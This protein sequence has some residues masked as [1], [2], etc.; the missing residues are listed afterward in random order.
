ME[1][2][3][4]VTVKYNPDD[5]IAEITVIQDGRSID[6]L[7][8]GGSKREL[9]VAHAFLESLR[10]GQ[11]PVLLGSGAGYALKAIAD[12]CEQQ[13]VP[14]LVIDGEKHILEAAKT[15]ENCGKSFITWATD[16]DIGS[17]TKILTAWQHKHG[18]RA[19]KGCTLPFYQ[20]SNKDF[21]A[22]LRK[23]CE[24]S[25]QF[26][27]WEKMRYTR[28]SNNTPKILILTS[29]YFLTGEITSACQRLGIPFET[30]TISDGEVHRAGFVETLLEAIT[31]FQPDFVFT[32]NHLGVD[33]EGVLIDLLEKIELPLASWFVDNPMLILAMYDKLISP[34]TSIFTWDH[35]NIP[36]LKEMGFTHVEY[37]SLGTDT[38]RFVPPGKKFRQNPDWQADVSF[39]GNSMLRKVASRLEKIVVPNT[40][41]DNLPVAAAAFGESSERSIPAFLQQCF[42]QLFQAYES[43]PHAE[44]RLGYQAALTWEATRQYRFSCVQAMFPFQPL[45][46]GDTGWEDLIPAS[47]IWKKHSELN[48]Y[49]DLPLFYPCSKI[50]FNCTSKQMK[51]AVNQRVFDVPAAGA[52]LL[53]DYREQVENLF[54]PG[55]EI[56]CYHSPEEAEELIARYLNNPAERKKIAEAAYKRILREHSY[57]HRVRTLI[58]A[59]SRTYG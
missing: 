12:H 21:Y 22:S 19:L 34:I 4:T 13:A 28:F 38:A 20:R 7:G 53:T 16:G 57:E 47:V 46:V 56:I 29:K 32:I 27:I 54:E 37:L 11:L 23:Y 31:R 17:A 30:L 25:S 6:M 2:K 49:T 44:N 26:N 52:F 42:P 45:I 43:I 18:L 36:A 24:A 58:E 5:T 35:D 48:Y 15:R 8:A 9:D 55:K 3:P 40:L 51:G 41:V 59:M 10:P 14:L 1:N 33:R 50:N 39:V